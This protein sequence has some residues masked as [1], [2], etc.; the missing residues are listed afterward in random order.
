MCLERRQHGEH[1]EVR[2]GLLPFVRRVGNLAREDAMETPRVVARGIE[3]R[4]EEKVVPDHV[5]ALGTPH[6]ATGRSKVLG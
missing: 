1:L 4:E 2:L 5:D 3:D 6:H